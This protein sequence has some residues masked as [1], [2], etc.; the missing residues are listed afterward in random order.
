MQ[1]A[2]PSVELVDLSATEVISGE[3]FPVLKLKATVKY[4]SKEL[5]VT[6]NQ[7]FSI[8]SE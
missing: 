4:L 6:L 5:E 8:L 7:P 1:L 2:A 3:G